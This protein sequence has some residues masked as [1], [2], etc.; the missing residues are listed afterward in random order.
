AALAGTL[1]AC[2]LAERLAVDRVVA[3]TCLTPL[4]GGEGDDAAVVGDA[5]GAARPVV[6]ARRFGVES[7]WDQ[8]RGALARWR[9][10]EAG[11][12]YV[13]ELDAPWR[14]LLD[15]LEAIEREGIGSERARGYGRVVFFDPAW[16][17]LNADKADEMGAKRDGDETQQLVRAAEEV[18]RRHFVADLAPR[19]GKGLTKSQMSQLIGVCQEASCHEEVVNY[20]RYQAGRQDAPWTTDLVGAVSDAIEAVFTAHGMAPDE[21]AR[22][23]SAWQRFATYLA[24]S[25]TWYQVGGKA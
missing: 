3:L 23:L 7:G 22:R 24:R 19:K 14:A 10:V 8:R 5:I 13:F 6:F 17:N 20:L 21:H 4:I 1:A 2:G 16:S 9:S 12:V 11:A 15:R 25:F 18:M